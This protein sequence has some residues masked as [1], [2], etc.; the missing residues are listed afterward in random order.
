MVQTIVASIV[1]GYLANGWINLEDFQSKT[2]HTPRIIFPKNFSLLGETV[3]EELGKKQT[4]K[5]TNILLL[6]I[7]Q[8]FIKNLKSIFNDFSFFPPQKL[9]TIYVAFFSPYNHNYN[10]WLHHYKFHCH[11]PQHLRNENICQRPP[12]QGVF[13]GEQWLSE[14][15]C[16]FQ[17]ERLCNTRGVI[18]QYFSSLGLAVSEELGNKKTHKHSLLLLKKIENVY[19]M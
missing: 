5:L 9:I 19:L 12:L 15:R 13:S 8:G 11:L 18:P 2:I 10:Q 3:S 14:S 6:N 4:D 16:F 17:S 1:F 7:F